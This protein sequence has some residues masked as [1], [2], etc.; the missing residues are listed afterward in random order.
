MKFRFFL[1]LLLIFSAKLKA[2]NGSDERNFLNVNQSLNWK[3]TFNDDGTKDWQKKWFIDGYRATIHNSEEGMLFSAGP[4]DGDDACHAV[5]WT[6]QSFNG[7]IKITYDYTRTDARNKWVNIIYIQAT[8]IDKGD[9]V[10]DIWK[11]RELRTI[12][13]MRTYFN[14][15]K[16]LHISYAAYGNRLDSGPDYIRVRK[17]P[18]QKGAVFNTSTEI[19]PSFF[20]TKL[21]EPGKTYKITIIKRKDTLYFQVKGGGHNNLYAWN[22]SYAGDIK[23]GRIGLR[24]MYTRSALFKDFKVFTIQ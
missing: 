1:L 4:V 16:A 9:Y 24:L 2:Q 12:P 7:D 22:I 8:G 3:L 11:W 6:K 10:K 20:D 23:E 5:L 21:F 19:L 17:Y 18:L 14:N 15:M 13:F